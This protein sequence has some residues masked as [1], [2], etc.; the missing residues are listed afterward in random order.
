MKDRVTLFQ[1]ILLALAVLAIGSLVYMARQQSPNRTADRIPAEAEATTQEDPTVNYIRF[2]TA[3]SDSLHDAAESMVFW[4]QTTDDTTGLALQTEELAGLVDR[5]MNGLEQG[6]GLVALEE[7][8]LLASLFL[9][10]LDAPD[11]ALEEP[12]SREAAGNAYLR[13]LE[14]SRSEIE[15]RLLRYIGA[16]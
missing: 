11:L 3:A 6:A 16:F 5:S 13:G 15:G 9:D 7:Y 14:V 12:E 2:I 1:T 4:L 8:D 10:Y